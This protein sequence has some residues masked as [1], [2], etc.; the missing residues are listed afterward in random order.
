MSSLLPDGFRV[1]PVSAEDAPAVNTLVRATDVAVQ[2]WSDTTETDLLDWWRLAD[3]ERDSWLIENGEVAAYGLLY[4]H[5]ATADLDC[6]VHPAWKG[7]G[8]GSWLLD[9]GVERGRERGLPKAHTWAL[10]PDTDARRLFELKGFDEVRRY[11]RMQIELDAPPAPAE[12]PV[13]FRVDTFTMDD[14]RVFHAVLNEAFEEEWEW[15]AKPFERWLEERV[16]QPSFDPGLCFL[17]REGDEVVAA[18]RGEPERSGGGWIGAIGVRKPW[19][20]RGLGLALLRHAFAE[21]YRRGQPRIGL[22]VDVENPTGA[23][24]LYER[25]GMHVVYEAVAFEKMLT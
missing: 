7:R 8:L 20:T 25:A 21:F 3:L 12:W 15:V 1:R 4:A 18:L 9:R 16:N 6:F 17:V 13:R 23:T 22:G 2:G 19:R 14:A 5:G 10:A 24:R 11:F